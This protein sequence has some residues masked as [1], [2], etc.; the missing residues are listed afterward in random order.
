MEQMALYHSR[1]VQISFRK[2]VTDSSVGQ[3]PLKG[4]GPISMGLPCSE[5]G[6]AGL[7]SKPRRSNSLAETV[8]SAAAG[9]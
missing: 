2:R 1:K 3:P 8:I 7:S 6:S 5:L 4:D 9:S